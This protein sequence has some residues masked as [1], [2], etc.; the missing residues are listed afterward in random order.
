MAR[1]KAYQQVF[2]VENMLMANRT[3]YA[4]MRRKQEQDEEWL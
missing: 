2:D 4:A 3:T 1:Y